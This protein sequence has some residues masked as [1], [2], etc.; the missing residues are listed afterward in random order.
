M[1]KKKKR[2]TKPDKGSGVVIMNKSDY[3]SKMDFILQDNYK[4][5][6]L[7]PSSEFDN[8]AKIE[9]HI[10]RRLLQLKKEGLLP[11]KIYSRIRPTGSQRPRMYD[12]PK[13]HKQDVPLPPIL[14]MTGS[15]QHQLAQWLTSVIDPVL[16]L[17]SIHCISDSFTFT[18]KV[19]TFNFPP[20]VF[21]CSYDVCSHFSKVPLAET[22]EICADTLY[23]GEL[24][25]PPFPRAVFVELMQTATSSV[26]FSFNSII[27]RQIDGVAM[28]SPLGLSLANIFVGYH[29]AL[30]FKKSQQTSD[31]LSIR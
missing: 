4:F 29:E 17:Y 9:A 8:T 26:E 3:I 19:K 21:L 25:P 31:V 10:Q 24:T 28:G 30:L 16:S 5:E 22:I 2:V 15:A 7:G 11:S 27:H 23:N 18:V 12:L 6:N 14:L 13:I 1:T 20:F